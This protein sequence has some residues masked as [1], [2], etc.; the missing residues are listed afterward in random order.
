MGATIS[1]DRLE[2]VWPPSWVDIVALCVCVYHRHSSPKV[3]LP[4]SLP[5]AYYH[6]H[7]HQ[8]KT[9][10]FADYFLFRLC[11]ISSTIQPRRW[12]IGELL[13]L[14]TF[15]TV[16]LRRSRCEIRWRRTSRPIRC[17]KPPPSSVPMRPPRRRP[18]IE[19]IAHRWP[20][21]NIRKGGTR[22]V[23]WDHDDDEEMVM[24]SNFVC[25]L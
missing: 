5:P 20:H 6:H 12:L 14:P 23:W 1:T 22:S 9:F 15:A 8:S 4:L 19:G 24:A 7:Y 11:V 13:V 3:T 10:R 16:R 17:A 2:E 18:P 25:S 21:H